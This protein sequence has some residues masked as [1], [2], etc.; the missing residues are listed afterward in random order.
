MLDFCWHW[1]AHEVPQRLLLSHSE[2]NKPAEAT[3]VQASAATV[4]RLIQRIHFMALLSPSL[5]TFSR[6]S[7]PIRD[8]GLSWFGKGGALW[9]PRSAPLQP[10]LARTACSWGTH[11]FG[12]GRTAKT[13]SPRCSR[14]PHPAERAIWDKTRDP[15]A[16]PFLPVVLCYVCPD[17]DGLCRAGGRYRRDFGNALNISSREIAK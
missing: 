15:F 4:A 3:L 14:L 16:H 5:G 9:V 2:S 6:P 11:C 13:F 8:R 1:V 7:W 10:P 17:S 12:L